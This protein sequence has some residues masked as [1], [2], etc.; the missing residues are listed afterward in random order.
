VSE[1][2]PHHLIVRV[3]SLYDY[4]G[5]INIFSH[6]YESLSSGKT[7]P[8]FTDQISNPI[9]APGAADVTIG[10]L[11][12]NAE[13]IM[14]VGGR[15]IVSRYDFA[16]RIAEYFDFDK[17]LV[18]ESSSAERRRPARRPIRAGLDCLLTEA[19]LGAPM[20]GITDDFARLRR[21]MSGS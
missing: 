8:G 6:V 9:A 21:E 20:P 15:D 19:F 3:N 12:K 14:H 7:V 13:G 11:S 5:R 16:C 10:L 2:S 17:K 1:A 4:R 18:I